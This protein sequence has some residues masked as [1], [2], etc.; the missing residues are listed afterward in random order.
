MLSVCAGWRRGLHTTPKPVLVPALRTTAGE[1]LFVGVGA[2]ITGF[3]DPSRGDMIALLG[4]LTGESALLRLRDAM[5]A[6]EEGRRILLD[7]PRVRMNTVNMT[8]LRSLPN[9]TFGAA[10]AKYMDKYSFSPDERTEARLVTDDTLRYIMQ[11]YREAHDFWHVLSGLPPTVMGETAVKWLEMVHTGLPMAALSAFV[12]PLRLSNAELAIL[13]SVYIPWAV[14]TGRHCRPLLCVRYEALF[15]E[16][17]VDV[18][19]KLQ[20]D[21]APATRDGGQ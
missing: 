13:R 18:R 10:Y 19:Q 20:F 12:A 11:R 2:A 16:P 1:R 17:L 4:E 14:T 7:R 6:D 8:F 5:L 3:I 15:S 9:N 21:A